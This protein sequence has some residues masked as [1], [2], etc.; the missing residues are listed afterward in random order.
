ME[1]LLWLKKVVNPDHV[2][3]ADD[4]FGLKPGWIGHFDEHVTAANAKVP[5]KCLSRVDLLLK[6]D[7][8]AHLR[9]AGCETVWVGAESGSQKVLD[10]MEKGTTV[11]QIRRASNLLHKEGIR[12][13]FFLQYGY[14]GETREDIDQTLRMVKECK[15]DEI[16][17]S[18]SYPLPGTRFYEQVKHEL[19]IKKNWV[20]SGDLDLMYQGTYS[21]DFYR[22]L[23]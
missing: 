10:A 8:V 3:F 11:Q 4:I 23:H 14:P 20:D 13:G 1:E 7:N 6:E 5:F 2:W 9:H 18:V 17:V 21:P 15:P 22:G 16:G 12:V 19:E